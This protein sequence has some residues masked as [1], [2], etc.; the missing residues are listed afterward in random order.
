MADPFMEEPFSTG[1]FVFLL[2]ICILPIVV[3]YLET[4]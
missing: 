3:I 1:E 4:R 2:L